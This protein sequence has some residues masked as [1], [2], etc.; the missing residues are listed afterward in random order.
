MVLGL[1]KGAF[2]QF[3]LLCCGYFLF[4]CSFNMPIPELPA[5]LERLG[6]GRY[7]GL[8]I[9]LFTLMA[10]LSRP[11]SGKL[12]DTIGRIPVMLF[13][14]GVCV[15]SS[16][17][18]PVLGSVSAFLLL[19]FFHGLSTG[20]LPTGTSSYVADIIPLSRRGQAMGMLGLSASLG[21]SV[22]PALGSY[23]TDQYGLTDMFYLSSFAGL[24]AMAVLWTMKESLPDKKRFEGR[25]LHVPRKEILDR[26]AIPPSVVALFLYAAY[27]ASLTLIPAVSIHAGLSNKGIFFTFFTVGSVGIRLLAGKIPDRYGRVPALKA[28]S[29]IMLLSMLLIAFSPS[30]FVLLSAAV[31]YGI[32]VGIFAPAAA[33]W[34]VDLAEEKHRGRALAT[35]YI[36][37]EAGIGGGALCS[38]WLYEQAGQDGTSTFVVMGLLAL[39]SCAYLQFMLPGR[40]K[41]KKS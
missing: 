12:A 20:F 32:S 24:L 28:A 7:I 37:M 5:Y 33:A 40:L 27:G 41:R 26:K 25:M 39:A 16:L 18:Y 10:A 13:G 1:G 19:R 38:G 6:G 9:S 4:S 35:M 22:G 23:I 30:P 31:L 3:I 2:R 29:G 36:A 14:S 15:V 11:V 8:I 34:T 21:F 17:L